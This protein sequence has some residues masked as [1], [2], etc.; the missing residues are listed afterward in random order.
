MLQSAMVS[1]CPS[2][3]LKPYIK[4]FTPSVE[5]DYNYVAVGYVRDPAYT[6][7]E[8]AIIANS[9]EFGSVHNAPMPHIRPAVRAL[10][11]AVNSRIAAKL[12]AAGYVD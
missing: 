3:K 7:K 5:G 10:R 1:R 11:S 12:K 8:I 9:V 6:P 4:I 2:D